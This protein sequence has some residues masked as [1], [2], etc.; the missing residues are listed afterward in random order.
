MK[1]VKRVFLSAICGW[2]TTAV[3]AQ[4]DGVP[5]LFDMVH[6]N[7]G[8]AATV[9]K[10]TNPAF[11]KKTGFNG[12]VP[13][14]YI[15]CALTYEAFDKDLFPEGSKEKEWILNKRKE[16]QE[17]LHEAEKK[18][19]NVYAFTDVMVLPTLLL[20]KYQN[21]MVRPSERKASFNVI[22]GRLAP[23]INQ[24][25]TEK[26]MQAQIDEIFTVF[27]ELD[28]LVIRFGETYLYDTP[29]HSGGSPIRDG[30]EAGI[31][32]HV[33]FINLLR[34]VVCEK[35]GKKLFYRTWGMDSFH[36]SVDMFRKITEQI[37]PHPNLVFSIKYTEGDF[38]RLVRFNRTIDAGKHPFIIEFQGQPEYCGKGAHPV[39]V[40]GGMLRGFEENERLLPESPQGVLQFTGDPRLQ[41]IWTWS[42]GGGWRGPYIS[43][44]LWCDVNTLAAAIWSRDTCLT[45]EEVLRKTAQR[46]G[47][48]KESVPDFIQLL[49]LAEKGVVR[50][51]YSLIDPGKSGFNIWWS[52]DQYF[53]GE[54]SLS[55]F[56]TYIIKQDMQRQLLEEKQEAN[57]I[58]N[59]I[60][61]LAKNIQ[62]KDK[63]TEQ[64]LRV[65]ATYGRIKHAVAA[66]AQ[67]L[68]MYGKEYQLSGVLNKEVMQDI[69][70]RYDA[71]W[72]EWNELKKESCCPTLYEPLAFSLTGKEGV[73]GTR[74]GSLEETVEKYRKLIQ[75]QEE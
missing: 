39:Y 69:I 40:F 3:F 14:W 17:K 18:G 11:L 34:E 23:D 8:E 65:S 5:Y 49:K 68:F 58:W 22:H 41:G 48:K 47:V 45:E 42:R 59:E 2:M 66:I 43:N 12:M 31:A 28:G 6:N 35:Y 1:T 33:K 9:S 73:S 54:N 46:I 37:E 15:Q 10:Y 60:E 53:S 52:R 32:A 70:T 26:V 20:E 19:M 64:F 51:Q 29:Y 44:E 75:T 4:S 13:Q 30:G 50:A 67:E 27:P 16:V 61:Q 72:K 56:M 71:L 21:Q 74:N 57:K 24:P 63:E 7:P 38:H 55:K 36:T 25:L 62:M